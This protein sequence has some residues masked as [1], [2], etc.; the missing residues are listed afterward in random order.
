MPN[1]FKE[2]LP[3][4]KREIIAYPYS[5]DIMGNTPLE[6]QI[7]GDHYKKLKI[8]PVEY[9]HANS[10]PYFEGNVIKYVT[11]WRGKGGIKDLEKAKHVIDLL[12]SL[13]G[14]K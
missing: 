1:Q 14:G 4:E 3:E 11:R 10:I 6:T 12:I 9:I 2:A 7:G 13:E 5:C 8:Q